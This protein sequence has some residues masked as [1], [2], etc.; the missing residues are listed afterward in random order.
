MKQIIPCSL[1][2]YGKVALRICFSFVRVCTC[3]YKMHLDGYADYYTRSSS[4]CDHKMHLHRYKGGLARRNVEIAA[5]CFYDLAKTWMN[6]ADSCNS[7]EL[8]N[9]LKD[10]VIPSSGTKNV[11]M[12]R[13]VAL[14][15][16][17]SLSISVEMVVVPKDPNWQI[18]IN[19]LVNL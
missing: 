1:S 19:I 13:R 2:G 3:I 12:Q 16:S 14:I 9:W 6:K 4:P 11:R 8:T 15:L 17:L 18:Q 10:L 5:K 7:V